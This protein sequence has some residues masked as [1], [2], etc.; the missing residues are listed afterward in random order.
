MAFDASFHEKSL[1]AIRRIY[2]TKASCDI[3]HSL[4]MDT[5]KTTP[6]CKGQNSKFVRITSKDDH[7]FFVDREMAMHASTTIRNM[8]N[9]SPTIDEDEDNVVCLDGL[10][11]H[12]VADVCRYIYYN[13]YYTEAGIEVPDFDIGIENVVELLVA[14]DFLDC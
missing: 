7:E 10:P 14:A 12:I 4:L 1:N 9:V 8:L 13:T 5:D 2:E 6:G 11:S 3:I